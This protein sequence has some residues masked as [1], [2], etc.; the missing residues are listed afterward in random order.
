H[1]GTRFRLRQS[2]NDEI[3][4]LALAAIV[5][6]ADTDQG[7]ESQ[8]VKLRGLRVHG[9][10]IALVHHA[11]N[12]LADVAKPFGYSTIERRDPGPDVDDEQ[13][14]LRLLNGC[15]DLLFDLGGELIDVL[16]PHAA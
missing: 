15:F 10:R 8:L 16:D 1:R 14:N 12:R 7:I 13:N 6:S 5:L 3:E 9:R 11:D 4:Q 2:F